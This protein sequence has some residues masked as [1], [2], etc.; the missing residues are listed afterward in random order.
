MG[1]VGN[2]ESLQSLAFLRNGRKATVAE[3]SGAGWRVTW[4]SAVRWPRTV[5]GG[6]CSKTPAVCLK[7]RLTQCPEL[8]VSSYSS[9]APSKGMI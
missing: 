7:P 5:S 4:S 2:T 9:D 8:T 3:A 1:T 6:V